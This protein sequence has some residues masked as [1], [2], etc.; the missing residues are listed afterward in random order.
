VNCVEHVDPGFITVLTKANEP[1]LELFNTSSDS[2]IQMESVMEDNQVVVLIGE[3]LNR[4]SN[5]RYKGV[6]HRVGKSSA[7]RYNMALELRPK[8]PIYYD[9]STLISKENNIL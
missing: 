4:L 2:W 7:S 9:W 3:T 8:V 1:G 5:G 6:L